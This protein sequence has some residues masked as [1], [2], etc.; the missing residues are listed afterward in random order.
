MGKTD[1]KAELA[2]GVGEDQKT[3]LCEIPELELDKDSDK[4]QWKQLG[5]DSTQLRLQERI[6]ADSCV[7]EGAAEVGVALL[8]RSLRAVQLLMWLRSL[9]AILRDAART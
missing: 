1:V 9:P 4:P 8:P 6:R 3:Y 7:G 5:H 2:I